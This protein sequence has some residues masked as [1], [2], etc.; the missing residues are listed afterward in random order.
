MFEVV[1]HAEITGNVWLLQHILIIICYVVHHL[2]KLTVNAPFC[3]ETAQTGDCRNE[4]IVILQSHLHCYYHPY[5]VLFAELTT[6]GFVYLHCKVLPIHALI[7]SYPIYLY[8]H[9]YEPLQ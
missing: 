1:H 2:I 4:E 3:S 6:Q 9:M 5:V 7:F 8:L